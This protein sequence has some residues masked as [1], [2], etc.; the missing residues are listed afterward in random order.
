M[1]KPYKRRKIFID[2]PLQLAVLGR[3]TLYWAMCTMTQILMVLFFGIITSSK[4]D[5]PALSPDVRWHLQVTLIASAVLLP[6]LLLDILKLSHRWVGPVFRL[7]NSLRSLGRGEAV[8]EVKFRDLDFWQ[9]LAVELNTVSAEL[10]RLR[11]QQAN[12]VTDD[13]AVHKSVQPLLAADAKSGS[14]VSPVSAPA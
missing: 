4:N 9:D 7:R 14:M 13:S 5:F 2:R 3:A 12:N 1:T 11:A 6:I 8:S 10:E